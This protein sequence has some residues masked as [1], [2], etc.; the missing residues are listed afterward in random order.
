MPS[1]V[2]QALQSD[3]TYPN[4]YVGT[5]LLDDVPQDLYK[6]DWWYRTSFSAPA[7]HTTYVLEFPGINYRAE[8][9]LNGHLVADSQR[10]V[11]MHAAHEVD[12]SP[13]VNRGGSNTL[14]VKITPEQALQDINGV[15][16]ADSWYDWINWKYL[17]YQGPGQESG[18]RQFL[19]GR[20]QCRNL[21]AG[22][23]EG[24][25]R[26]GDRLVDGEHRTSAAAHG[27]READDLQQPAQ[28]VGSAGSRR[29][30]GH[31]HA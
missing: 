24:L 6:Q 23:P 2:L 29:A 17:G 5:N 3:G 31:D 4:L 20:P 15:E 16:L 30:A 27:F 19:C 11:G 25:R 8:I 26:G 18:E 12:V 28:R 13:W 22:L 21:E 14:A 7:G 1:T 9:W 10:I